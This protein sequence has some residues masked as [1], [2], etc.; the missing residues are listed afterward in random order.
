MKERHEA[1]FRK[2]YAEFE[3]QFKDYTDELS[4]VHC[5]TLR[6]W[7]EVLNWHGENISDAYVQSDIDALN[8]LADRLSKLTDAAR[9]AFAFVVERGVEDSWHNSFSF[10]LNEMARRTRTTRQ[11]II[12]IFEE[13]KRYEFGHI[14]SDEYEPE[15]PEAIVYAPT[16]DQR[17][18]SEYLTGIRS[19]CQQTAIDVGEVLVELKF[20]LLDD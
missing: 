14:H 18:H 9:S 3:A 8:T 20:N 7:E 1:R 4:P 6:R 15:P 13:L 5:R 10:S 11:S 12:D 17:Y 2:A 19:Y 16:E